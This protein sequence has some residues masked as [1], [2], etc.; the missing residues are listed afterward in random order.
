MLVNIDTDAKKIC[1][2]CYEIGHYNFDFNIWGRNA[3]HMSQG[4]PEFDN[5]LEC[6]GVCDT[7]EQFLVKYGDTLRADSRQLVVSFT[8]VH[9]EPGTTDGWRW[10]K[11]GPYIGE[12]SPTTEYLADEKE[13]DSGVYCYQIYC[14]DEPEERNEN[15]VS[16][17]DQS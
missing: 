8:H 12:G 1:D 16:Q 14:L 3:K 9:K 7:P 13:F 11:W 6:Y 10:C 2:G 5:N 4:W 15:N 17:A